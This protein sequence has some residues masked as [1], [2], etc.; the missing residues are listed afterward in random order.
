[1]FLF[2]GWGRPT[3]RT[4]CSLCLLSHGGLNSSPILQT[5]IIKRNGVYWLFLNNINLANQFNHVSMYLPV[6]NHGQGQC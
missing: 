4:I 2:V 1:M 3:P 5:V 6:T